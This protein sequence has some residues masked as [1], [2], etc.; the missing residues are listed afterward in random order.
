M[1]SMGQRKSP[2][3]AGLEPQTEGKGGD[4]QKPHTPPNLPA[5]LSELR[6]RCYAGSF[7]AFALKRSASLI[8]GG[9]HLQ[10]H[11]SALG[12]LNYARHAQALGRELL[13]LFGFPHV[14]PKPC[15][16]MQATLY[17]RIGSKSL[18][19]SEGD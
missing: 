17:R 8:P 9:N 10:Q 12:V 11:R 4:R 13:I 7:S 2:A 5:T 6:Q 18:I 1:K 14:I 3:R 15:R 16:A 19:E